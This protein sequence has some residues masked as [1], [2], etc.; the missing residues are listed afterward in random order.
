MGPNGGTIPAW[1]SALI[2][3]PEFTSRLFP[4][5]GVGVGL[6]VF[7]LHKGALAAAAYSIL[8]ALHMA[9]R[10]RFP[11]KTAAFWKGQIL[12]DVS[13]ITW[14]T[15]LTGPITTMAVMLYPLLVFGVTVH[16]G[17]R[18]GTFARTAS[19]LSY[20]ALLGATIAGKVPYDAVTKGPMSHLEFILSS[21]PVFA[22]LP[23]WI[24]FLLGYLAVGGANVI[25]FLF[26]ASMVRQRDGAQKNLEESEAR[27]QSLADA[28]IEA[29]LLTDQGRVIDANRSFTR[30]FGYE[31][32]E[33][34]GR[35]AVDFFFPESRL[36]F[37]NQGA[38]LPESPVSAT[39]VRKDGTSFE[40]EVLWRSCLHEGRPAGVIA[41]RDLSEQRQLEQK[42]LQTQR[43]EVIGRLASG[44]AHD[45]NN[46]LTVVWGN[47][48]SA[49]NG[50]PSDARERRYLQNSIQGVADATSLVAQL[51]TLGHGQGGNR[52][53]V[54]LNKLLMEA[55][56][57]LLRIIG[58]GIRISAAPIQ[59]PCFVMGDAVQI[60]QIL[61]NLVLNARDAMNG[62]GTIDFAIEMLRFEKDLHHEYGTLPAG[63]YAVLSVRDTGPGMPEDVRKKCF[64]PFFTT[65]PAGKG[66]GLGLAT[67]A[68]I[69]KEH[70]GT[71]RCES[72]PGRG[73]VFHVY[74]PLAEAPEAAKALS[75][76]P[77][78][79]APLPKGAPHPARTILV[80]ED[81]RR[82]LE[83]ASAAL[84]KEG[85]RVLTAGTFA[86]A[87]RICETLDGRL[88]LLFTDIVLPDGNG[89]YLAERVARIHP[90]T[91]IIFTSG[92][93][94]GASLRQQKK[95]LEFLAK[96]YSQ[97]DLL[98]KVSHVLHEA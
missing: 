91:K 67:A 95:H 68:Q 86:E 25:T 61:L 58:A 69:A 28:S 90:E 57:M 20:M 62:R 31:A 42:F 55:T 98:G 65:K 7:G 44:V 60:E 56:R 76:V 53:P 37:F 35:L 26:A 80:T 47:M 23:S 21:N 33:T 45:F 73:T 5:V 40:V 72:H 22:P 94:T 24:P 34:K 2:N 15:H 49:L 89:A 74:L 59:I 14:L 79:S 13:A 85:H 27:F 6:F 75:P 77:E 84:Q 46:L 1:K 64:E 93:D 39:A 17:I 52:R 9:G 63:G 18:D 96:P 87:L 82:V 81:D 30:L 19:N 70:R 54:D 41:I 3:N 97:H 92:Y 78:K 88:D 48:E 10:R 11:S 43:M 51:L 71:I 16:S 32:A 66:T 8:T 12:L 83:V 4:G 29:I 38:V 50:L 36:L